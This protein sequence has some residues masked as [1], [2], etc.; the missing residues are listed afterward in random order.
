MKYGLIVADNGT[1][2]F[3]S[4]NYDNGW[5]MGALNTA[6]N[7][8]TSSDFEVVQRGYAMRYLAYERQRVSLGHVLAGECAFQGQ[9]AFGNI[10]QVG[11]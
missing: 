8:L 11:Y 5:N 7:G 9:T 1:D 3:I 10:S 4:G 2:M 6:F